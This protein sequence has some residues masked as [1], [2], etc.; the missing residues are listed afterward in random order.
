M[1]L[2]QQ[3]FVVSLLTSIVIIFQTEVDVIEDIDE[4]QT[5]PGWLILVLR[6]IIMV[7][8]L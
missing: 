5:W 8:F 4:Y 6:N 1:S 7:W 3:A 2:F